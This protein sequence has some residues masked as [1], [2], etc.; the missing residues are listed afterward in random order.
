[1]SGLLLAAHVIVA[2]LLIAVVL[3]QTGKGASLAGLFGGGTATESLFTAP[4][5][6]VFLQRVTIGLATAFLVTS[7]L[8]TIT[9]LRTPERTVFESI[10]RQPASAAPAP[11]APAAPSAASPAPAEAP[12]AP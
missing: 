7:L 3:I 1:M 6:N 4:G 5:G 9:S 2:V 10:P 11:A 12:G 8:L